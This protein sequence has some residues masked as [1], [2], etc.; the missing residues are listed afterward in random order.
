MQLTIELTDYT[1]A[2]ESGQP[3][4][5]VRRLNA[6]SELT[7][8]LVGDTPEF[9]VPAEGSRLVLAK[10]DGTSIF[11]GY[12]THTPEFEYL[13]WG[14]QGPVYRYIV[15]AA[16][17]EYLLDRKLQPIRAPFVA[18]AAG[19]MLK[20][21]VAD[22]ALPFD[23][24]EVASTDVVP[25][26]ISESES[27]WSKQ[28]AQLGLYAR[29]AWRVQDGKLYFAPVGST[30]HVIDEFAPNYSPQGLR[31]TAV[32]PAINDV[33]VIGETS[34]PQAHV[35]DYFLGD[36]VTLDFY[37]S[38]TPFLRTPTVFVEDE[39][40]G[41]QLNAQYWQADPGSAI[42][43]S[44]GQLNVAGAGNVCFVER[45]ELG[46]A[47]V[48]QHGEI[49][50]TGPSNGIIGGLFE[51]GLAQANCVAGFSASPSG[52][53]TC[54]T[55][56]V[57][58]ATAGTPFTTQAGHVYALTSRLYASEV[59][60][61]EETYHSSV[62]PVGAGRGGVAV[63]ADVH[64][65]LEIHDIDPA[66]PGSN[67]AISTILYDG[68]I[69]NAPGFC[70]YALI[71]GSGLQCSFA[72]TRLVQGPDFEVC[73]TDPGQA[74]RTRLIGALSEG[75]ECDF[76]STE[77]EFYSQ[78]VPAANEAIKLTYRSTGLAMG[79]VNSPASI[80][81]LANVDSAANGQA[82]APAAGIIA[83]V[84]PV[85]VNPVSSMPDDG[86]RHA[87]RRVELPAART[88]ADCE[89]AALAILD[90]STQQAWTGQY[91]VPSDFLPNDVFPGDAVA[92]NVPSLS[93]NFQATV[94]EVEIQVVDLAGDRSQYIIAF[95]NDAAKP[96]FQFHTPGLKDPVLV[97]TLSGF[98]TAVGTECLPAVSNAAIGT[99]YLPD[100][101]AAEVTNVTSTG[102]SIDCGSAPPAG[103]GFEVRRSDA[104][105]GPGNDRN[106]AGHFTTQ[107]ISL[108]RLTRVQTYY[109]RQYDADGHYSRNTT[110]LHVDY[111]YQ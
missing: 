48:L 61:L 5:V 58:G 99:Q 74:P 6:P 102:I 70:S 75:A 36:G 96:W 110:V 103:G 20:Q 1:F 111:P 47:V 78:Y 23:T 106:L 4:K 28:A 46:G 87:V 100:V 50:F 10:S 89:N 16:S 59:F 55:P 94:S 108:P 2:I 86:V 42:T 12:L 109:L 51:N 65:V 97:S 62:Q 80:S 66:N 68:T 18:R 69:T 64:V 13:G 7:L 38:S 34:S 15:K 53:Q 85:V 45:I 101:M 52:T 35:K 22:L 92:V 27:A 40:T 29:A 79:R 39:F 95:A 91:G 26:Y 90:D 60:R 63:P 98:T 107:T 77:L 11:T 25:T 37:L 32:A 17:D 44:G 19:E 82:G 14:A 31:L 33:I 3:L 30:V 21:R 56:V 88:S 43:V 93:A 104:T 24:S 105:W 83:P 76:S 8:C 9:L 57:S 49:A 54:I 67:G 71:A 73:S 81:A 41:T 84:G 72:F